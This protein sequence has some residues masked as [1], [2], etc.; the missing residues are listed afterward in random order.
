MASKSISNIVD[1][2]VIDKIK[3]S[4][5]E[6]DYILKIKELTKIKLEAEANAYK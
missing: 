1:N 2:S 4:N 3:S 6:W 5:K